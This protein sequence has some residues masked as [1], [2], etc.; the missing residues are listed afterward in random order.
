MTNPSYP[1][2]PLANMGGDP[3]GLPGLGGPSH[4]YT[5]YAAAPPAGRPRTRED[6]N[7]G[8]WEVW[9]RN[10]QNGKWAAFDDPHLGRPYAEDLSAKYDGAGA[11]KIVP[12][13]PETNERLYDLE[14]LVPVGTPGNPDRREPSEAAA[15]SPLPV[16]PGAA[17][18]GTQFDPMALVDSMNRALR[19]MTAESAAAAERARKDTADREAKDAARAERRWENLIR[20]GAPAL[21]I[22]V[23]RFANPPA[24]AIVNPAPAPAAQQD[25]MVAAIMKHAV[26]TMLNP[27]RPDPLEQLQGLAAVQDLAR[28]IADPHGYNDRRW[29]EDDRPDEPQPP[30]PLEKLAS[31]ATEV[32]LPRMMGVPADVIA[33]NMMAQDQSAPARPT[34]TRHA[35]VDSV[36]G[37]PALMMQIADQDPERFAN[38]AVDLVKGSPRFA[39]ALQRTFDQRQSELAPLV[40]DPP[41]PAAEYPGPADPLPEQG[42]AGDDQA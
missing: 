27:R 34:A 36:M 38:M 15:A 1:A 40:A 6:F 29:D 14:L 22:L 30:T 24:P 21:A 10:P 20:F 23:N 18:Y 5:P 12:I 8:K 41:P 7:L 39:A 37:N 28:Q 26:E 33:A 9:K 35:L 25:P 13:D 11:Y 31:F 42:Y 16:A 19:A 17:P 32:A 4:S 3:Q 2:P